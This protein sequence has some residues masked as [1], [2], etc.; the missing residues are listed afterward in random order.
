MKVRDF[1]PMYGLF[2][3]EYHEITLNNARC[4]LHEVLSDPSYELPDEAVRQ[5]NHFDQVALHDVLRHVFIN[6][7]MVIAILQNLLDAWVKQGGD[8]PSVGCSSPTAD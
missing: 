4:P 1:L 3:N 5:I 2:R 8:I 6:P 7:G